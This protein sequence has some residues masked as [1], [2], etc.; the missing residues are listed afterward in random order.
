MCIYVWGKKKKTLQI[1]DHNQNSFKCKSVDKL[2]CSRIFYIYIYIP[3]GEK[4]NKNKTKTNNH[5]Q[6]SCKCPTLSNMLNK[7]GMVL[8]T[9]LH[10]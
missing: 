2:F 5:N 4:Q 8:K 1:N 10:K 7:V 9:D 3:V 6:N